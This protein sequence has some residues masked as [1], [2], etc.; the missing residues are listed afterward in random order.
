M[1]ALDSFDPD[2]SLARWLAL[3]C[4]PGI[5]RRVLQRLRER[6]ADPLRAFG[7]PLP[8]LRAWS[9]PRV[10]E[11][12]SRGPDLA[13]ARALWA[14]LES[15]GA[16]LISDSEPEFPSALRVIPDPPL[17]LYVRGPLPAEPALA[18]VGSRKATLRGRRFTE[19]IAEA[20][21]AS[22]IPVVSGLA[23]GIDA[24]AH[25]GALRGSRAG[26][27]PGIAVWASGFD[28]PAPRGHT[29]LA[30]RWLEAGG[31]WITE[32]PPGQTARPH[33]FPER[34]RLVSGLSRATLVVEAQPA[35]GS[36][37]TAK[38]ALDQG[39]EVLAV[40]GPIDVRVCRG[41]NELLRDGAASV[42]E[43]ADVLALFGKTSAVAAR[44]VAPTPDGIAGRVWLAL[45]RGPTE[46]DALAQELALD[47]A[48][49][50]RAVTE[51]ELDGWIVRSGALLAQR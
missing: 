32:Y 47:S 29:R 27:A 6:Y 12:L 38:H 7:R 35:S 28:Q 9:P 33:Q 50:A 8:E 17:T 36:L 23:Y 44:P 42:L 25:E 10:A 3:Q 34:N 45:A 19:S 51:L 37:W 48:A 13:A 22:G 24:A 16:R 15:L 26:S 4:V 2:S 18:I 14:R 49:L 41:S 43:P 5:S 46:L 39:R 31:A 30:L 20:A 11:Q 21:V 1:L 40:P